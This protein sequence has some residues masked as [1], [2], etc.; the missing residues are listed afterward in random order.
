MNGHLFNPAPRFGFAY[1]LFGD[2]KT[3]IRG[4]Y[5]IFFEHTN[6]NEANTESLEGQSSPLIQN[7]TQYNV[8][9]YPNIGGGTTGS[10]PIFPL[11]FI[12]IPTQ[13]VWP[14][15]QQW[16]LDIQRELTKNTVLVLA[17]VG[18]KGTH[19]NRQDDLNQLYPVPAAQNPY[20]PGEPIGGINNSSGD[21]TT[22]TTPS[23]VPITGQAAINLGV[24]CGGDPNPFR[25]FHGVG[26]I[27][28]LQNAA[29]STYN[30]FQV[31]ARKTAGALQFTLAYTWSHSIDDSS[32]R[33]DGDFV[34]TYDPAANR[35]SSAFDIR[36]MLNLG[37]VY[38]LPFFH[39]PGLTNKILGG[40]QYS[41][42]LTALT[43]EHHTHRP[44]QLITSDNAGVGN[45]VSRCRV[46]SGSDRRSS[47]GIPNC[48]GFRVLAP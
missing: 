15:I 13:A 34:N 6:G 23:G 32:D 31:S 38:D 5:G 3:A 36:H 45:S 14:Y 21:C 47:T 1:D 33:Y 18:S 48:S 12:S 30:A 25:R 10:T 39:K 28:Q 37:W 46:L 8:S 24:A 27:T 40:W 16:H 35:A 9:G 42:I 43:G 41:G 22:F 20:L 2:G 26:T 44:T 17:Y 11:S 19:L 29:S 4:G 7:V